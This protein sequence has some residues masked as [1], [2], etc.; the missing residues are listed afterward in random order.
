MQAT[1]QV[2]TVFVKIQIAKNKVQ[3][4]NCELGT[5][6][7]GRLNDKVVTESRSDD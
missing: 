2:L 1:F 4:P 5:K 7:A 6:S 3:R